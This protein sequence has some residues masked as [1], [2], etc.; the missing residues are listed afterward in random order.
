MKI[1]D[2][3]K[4]ITNRKR[5]WD[6]FSELDQKTFNTFI[7]NRFLS[8]NS[9]WIDF[10]N[11]LQVYTM[12]IPLKTKDVYNLYCDIFPKSNTFLRYVKGKKEKKYADWATELVCKYFEVGKKEATD[13]LQIFYITKEGKSNLKEII[14][15]YGVEESMIKKLRL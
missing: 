14:S 10:L 15:L 9:E 13:Y 5:P 2:W 11:Y 7:I 12:G 8:M 1:F 3:L 6:S 4:E